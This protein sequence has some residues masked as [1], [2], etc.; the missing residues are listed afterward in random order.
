VVIWTVAM[1]AVAIVL[2]VEAVLSLNAGQQECFVNYPA[3][4]CPE[5]DDP[6][7]VRLTVAFF[8]IPLAWLI[9][10]G[11]LGLLGVARRRASRHPVNR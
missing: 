11:V 7:V 5:R 9:G 6:A 3:T 2:A 8:G 1:L 4:P 10:L